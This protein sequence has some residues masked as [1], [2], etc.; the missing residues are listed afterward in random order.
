MS[1][2][3]ADS[4]SHWLPLPVDT[5]L[6]EDSFAD[7]IRLY[8]TRVSNLRGETSQRTSHFD[9]ALR[10]RQALANE[11]LAKHSSSNPEAD[12]SDLSGNPTANVNVRVPPVLLSNDS[13]SVERR[14]TANLLR[15]SSSYFLSKLDFL[16]PYNH[17][18]TNNNNSNNSSSSRSSKTSSNNNDRSSTTEAVRS[19]GLLSPREHNT[20][21]QSINLNQ[22]QTGISSPSASS[23]SSPLP[24][25]IAINTTISYPQVPINPHYPT[26]PPVITQYPPKPLQYSPVEPLENSSP[27]DDGQG[28]RKRA[29]HRISLP[30][31]RLQ[32]TEREHR[33]RSE[34]DLSQHRFGPIGKKAKRLTQWLVC[35]PSKKSRNKQSVSV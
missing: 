22:R 10:I 11:V 18:Q 27:Q 6:E 29:I 8:D 25:I 28:L 20:N 16:N 34:S 24:A 3:N 13:A 30:F 26:V 7:L 21:N 23:G 9:E 31:L 19:L 14:S 35:S 12:A 33:R 2:L 4:V 17:H 1:S 15:R 5:T 32:A